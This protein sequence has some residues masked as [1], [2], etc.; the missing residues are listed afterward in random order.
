MKNTTV[1]A[2]IRA[3]NGVKTGSHVAITGFYGYRDYS[4]ALARFTTVDPIRDGTN[5][6][7]YVNNDPVNYIDLWGLADIVIFS[8]PV[9]PFDKHLFIG[10]RTEDGT[11]KTKSLYP[12]SQIKAVQDVFTGGMQPAKLEYN[13]SDEFETATKYFAN[14]PLPAFKNV[15]AIIAPPA[16]ISQ[17]NFDQAVL[18]A[19]EN[20]PVNERPYNATRGPNSNTYVDDVIE[21]TGAKM[22]DINGATQQNWGEQCSK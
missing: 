10:V 17:E 18:K 19:A 5:W 6:F 20:Y 12:E 2:A 15:E 14:E 3:G 4:P 11:V 7:A 1:P 9:T 13:K 16:G 22:P 21:S 8:L